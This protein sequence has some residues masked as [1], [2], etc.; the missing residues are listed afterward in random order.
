MLSCCKTGLEP[1]CAPR[2]QVREE[3]HFGDKHKFGVLVSQKLG[4]MEDEGQSQDSKLGVSCELPARH[5]LPPHGRHTVLS[6]REPG[7]PRAWLWCRQTGEARLPGA[8]LSFI[9]VFCFLVLGQI[10]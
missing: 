5:C 8:P 1:A 4:H 7:C 3:P 6:V 9:L 2:E 10:L